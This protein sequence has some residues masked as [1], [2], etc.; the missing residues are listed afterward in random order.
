MAIHRDTKGRYARGWFSRFAIAVILVACVIFGFHGYV[1]D[2]LS[3]EV[4]YSA[5]VVEADN[6]PQTLAGAM[7]GKKVDTLKDDVVEAIAGCESAGAKDP[8]GLIVFDTNNEA[9]IGRLQFQRK[10]V[11]HYVKKFEDRD[12]DMS[13]AVAIAIDKDKATSLAKRIMFEEKEGWR[14]WFN[15]GVK[16]DAGVKSGIIN[17]L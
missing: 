15:C 13:D 7:Y 10:T 14:N 4:S 1:M 8:D 12:I 17:S 6:S 16:V 9:S 2:T 11:I 5:T 3:D